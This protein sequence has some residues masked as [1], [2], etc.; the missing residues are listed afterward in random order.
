MTTGVSGQRVPAL[1]GIRGL[2]ILAVLLGHG[3]GH[4]AGDKLSYFGVLL[5]F[6]LSGYLITGRLLSGQTLRRF[7]GNRA[8]RLLPA[9]LLMLA[10]TGPIFVTLGTAWWRPLEAAFYVRNITVAHLGSGETPYKHMWSLALEE[11]F[12]LLWPIAFLLWPS[13][14][15]LA[16]TTVGLASV[17][18]MD[19]GLASGWQWVWNSPLSTAWSLCLGCALALLGW[20]PRWPSVLSWGW[21]RWFGV[22]SYG[23]YLWHYPLIILA[24]MTALPDPVARWVGIALGIGAAVI[25]WRYVETPWLRRSAEAVRNNRMDTNRVRASSDIPRLGQRG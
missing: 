4:G 2:A 7:Y 21:L 22:R 6:V 13:R 24:G 16:V 1:D 19:L 5:F 11:Q 18:L 20:A 23:M 12:Y 15:I 25:S 8:R 9:M 17:A 10:V 14:R 3:L